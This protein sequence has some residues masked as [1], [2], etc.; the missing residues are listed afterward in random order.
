MD[1]VKN[2]GY[3]TSKQC[4]ANTR[5]EILDDI[6]IW[7]RNPREDAPPVFW[8]H[9]TAGSG[10][11]AI[12]H[13]IAIEFDKD[14]QLGSFFPF[15]RTYL[16]ER[17]HEKVFTTIARDLADSN[18]GYKQAV[19]DVIKEKTW[20]KSTPDLSLQWDSLLVGP[21]IYLSDA[22][23]ILIVIDALDESGDHLSRTALL[24]ILAT[25]AGDLPPNIRILLTSRTGDDI[26]QA[27]APSPHVL[28]RDLNNV[29]KSSIDHDI[30]IYISKQ[31]RGINDAFFDNRI[32]VL[33]IR[34]EGL[35]QWAYV[36]CEFIKDTGRI[37]NPIQQF[38][39]LLNPVK[40]AVGA[41]DS[42]YDTVLHSM[43]C[44]DNDDA[45]QLFRS[46]MGQVLG[47][48]EPL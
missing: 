24:S 31:L 3:N 35:F 45:V 25:R 46:V 40:G 21:S 16:A 34:S 44:S 9:G 7:A 12:A 5:S 18:T 23:P 42:L 13:T 17:R 47:L 10:K 38:Y 8:L 33:V 15:D 11:S 4:L 28:S 1:C 29:S 41:L 48:S 27:L 36:A 26:L 2:N 43:L 30:S 32:Q 20:L 14:K 39:K 37:S 6:R 19:L 22:G